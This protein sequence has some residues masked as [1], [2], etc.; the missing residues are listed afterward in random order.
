M[1]F[2]ALLI[3][4]FLCVQ[5]CFYAGFL[6]QDCS[7]NFKSSKIIEKTTLDGLFNRTQS[8]D[9]VISQNMGAKTQIVSQ[10]KDNHI[11]VSGYVP[12]F[13][14]SQRQKLTRYIQNC[15]GYKNPSSITLAY[16]TEVN[17]HAP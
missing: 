6:T 17:P 1:N 7:Y 13:R 4:A 11:F 15:G 5:L 9:A 2:R 12:S 3:L 8:D 16:S 14:F 10:K